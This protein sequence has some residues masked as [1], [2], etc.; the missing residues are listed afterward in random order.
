MNIC[1]L[2]F[3]RLGLEEPHLPCCTVGSSLAVLRRWLNEM[4][5]SALSNH[6]GGCVIVNFVNK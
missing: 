5:G 4:I 3:S 2:G 1:P 6:F